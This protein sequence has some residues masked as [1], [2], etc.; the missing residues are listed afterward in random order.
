MATKEKIKKEEKPWEDWRTF[1]PET[2][3]HLTKAQRELRDATD[4]QTKRSKRV[5][6]ELRTDE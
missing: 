1:K 2:D 5:E 3:D 6:G 4:W